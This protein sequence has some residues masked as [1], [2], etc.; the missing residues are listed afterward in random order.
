MSSARFLP[1]P[2][3]TVNF[4]WVDAGVSSSRI[5]LCSYSLFCTENHNSCS[6]AEGIRT[7][8]LRR[9]ESKL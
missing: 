7:P 8:D 9:A 5:E 6:G 3:S 1:G 4:D 2:Q